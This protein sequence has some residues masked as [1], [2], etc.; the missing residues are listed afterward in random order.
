MLLPVALLA[1]AGLFISRNPDAIPFARDNGPLR[2]VIERAEVVPITPREV[3]EGYDTKIEIV[4]HTV[5]R[6]VRPTGVRN[7]DIMTSAHCAKM[8]LSLR[9]DRETK[10]LRALRNGKWSQ[11]ITKVGGHDFD[12]TILL[13]LAPLAVTAQDLVFQGE[14]DLH[15][16]YGAYTTKTGNGS[17]HEHVTAPIDIVVRP[18]K[19]KILTPQPS[20]YQP[21]NAESIIAE[22][23][24]PANSRAGEDMRIALTLRYLGEVNTNRKPRFRLVTNS[25]YVSD[26]KG[27]RYSRFMYRTAATPSGLYKGSIHE[28]FSGTSTDSTVIWFEMPLKQ[29]PVSAGRLTL[30]ADISV[31]DC[32]PRHVSVVVRDK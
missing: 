13:K 10:T 28:M 5:G 4:G 3:F 29:I 9:D 11:Q 24:L 16:W 20:H 21:L 30:H 19:Q 31:N 26:Q 6:S 2:L 17:L 14:A 8:R 22:P 18:A 27:R 1:G 15:R 23:V 32:W 7:I 12:S 25:V